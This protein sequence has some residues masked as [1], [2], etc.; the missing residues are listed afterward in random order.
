M[1]LKGLM[2]F[3]LRPADGFDSTNKGISSKHEKLILVDDQ[4]PEIFQADKDMPA[5]RLVCRF[6]NGKVYLHV[7]PYH[8]NKRTMFGGNFIHSSDSRFQAISNYPIPI[9]DRIE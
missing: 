5:I 4:L 7:I 1:I 6:I 3:V 8:E 2:V 9:H